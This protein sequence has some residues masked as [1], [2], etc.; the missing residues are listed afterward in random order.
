M[1]NK[2]SAY[3]GFLNQ[4]YY[5]LSQIIWMIDIFE[6]QILF[7]C[8]ITLENWYGYGFHIIYKLQNYS[9]NSDIIPAC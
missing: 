9:M 7:K 1:C 5:Y 2:A 6:Y 8:I 4:K 3:E